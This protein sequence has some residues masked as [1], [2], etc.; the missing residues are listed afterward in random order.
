MR[1]EAPR[2][3]ALL[4]LALILAGCRGASPDGRAKVRIAYTPYFSQAPILIAKE[5]GF[6]AR[7]GIDVELVPIGRT[8]SAATAALLSGGLDVATGAPRI[9]EFAAIARGAPIRF[10]ADKGHAGPGECSPGAFVARPDLF[11]PDGRIPLS[12][13]RGARV[14][15]QTY[16]YFEFLLSK[17]LSAE[18]LGLGD[19]RPVTLPTALAL[20][21][22]EKRQIALAYLAEAELAQALRHGQRVW[23]SLAELAPQSQFSVLTFGP[24]L[25]Q[26]DRA[27]GVRVLAAY[28]RGVRRYNEGKTPRNVQILARQTRMNPADITGAC[29]TPIRPD[30]AIVAPDWIEFQSWAESRDQIPRPVPLSL[31]TDADIL[32]AANERLA[33]EEA[34]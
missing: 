34:R 33:G 25:L 15:T 2:R 19:I 20:D 26:K 11:G 24:R 17:A 6:F 9:A 28:L 4:A 5:E 32:R 27:L 18:G 13:L 21:A 7:E 16:T 8:T 1:F 23:K 14:R 12:R 29:W 10:V 31:L 22:L 30:G 3:S